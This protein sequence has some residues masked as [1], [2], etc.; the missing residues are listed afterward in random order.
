M[1]DLNVL[2]LR[3]R[4]IGY[5]GL[6]CAGDA[7]GAWQNESCSENPHPFDDIEPA[8]LENKSLDEER[9]DNIEPDCEL[10]CE[11]DSGE[12][13]RFRRRSDKYGRLGKNVKFVLLTSMSKSS[14]D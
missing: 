7:T 14:V 5:C 2:L 3:R 11:S 13:E 4:K 1:S 9:S 6:P 12:D 10:A 8:A